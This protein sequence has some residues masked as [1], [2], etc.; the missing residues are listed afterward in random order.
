MDSRWGRR[1]RGPGLSI[2]TVIDAQVDQRGQ[3]EGEHGRGRLL[4]FECRRLSV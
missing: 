4:F 3:V 1:T 2:D